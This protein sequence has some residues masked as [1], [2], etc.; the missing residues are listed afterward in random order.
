MI[1]KVYNDKKRNRLI[2]T[3]TPHMQKGVDILYYTFF[4]GVSEGLVSQGYIDDHCD[5]VMETEGK[6]YNITEQLKEVMQ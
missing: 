6:L 1:Y 5:L 2:V 4:D 3:H